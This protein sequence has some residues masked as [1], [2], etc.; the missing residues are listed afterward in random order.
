MNNGKSKT[1][2]KRE[3][4]T[5]FDLLK[6]QLLHDFDGN[7]KLE[8]STVDYFYLKLRDEKAEHLD[9]AARNIIT[10]SKY[11]KFPTLF[12]IEDVLNALFPMRK[13][14]KEVSVD[15][16]KENIENQANEE[17][18]EWLKENKMKTPEELKILIDQI[19]EE[20]TDKT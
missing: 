13:I 20:K 18:E 16:L 5:F 14:V 15:A 17:T 8:L 4:T 9:A 19:V 3:V 6:S 7:P 12:V 1:L 2:S 10:E 11:K